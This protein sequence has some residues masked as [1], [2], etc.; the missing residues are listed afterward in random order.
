MSS[1]TR[2]M[3][4]VLVA[5]LMLAAT[6]GKSFLPAPWYTV[7]ALMLGLGI[8]L[9]VLRAA[10]EYRREH[11]LTN[12]EHSFSVG[13]RVP[14]VVLVLSSTATLLSVRTWTWQPR[15]DFDVLG[16]LWLL[17]NLAGVAL[18]SLFGGLALGA[19]VVLMLSAGRAD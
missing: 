18:V 2:V 5:A 7:T 9:V 17:Q 10:A 12:R 13:W 4:I 8:I 6:A 16:V 11:G 3:A 15:V 14:L 19:I 1:T